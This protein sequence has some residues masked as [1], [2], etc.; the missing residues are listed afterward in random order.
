MKQTLPIGTKSKTAGA[1]LLLL[2]AGLSTNPTSAQN[3]SFRDRI[4]ERMKERMAKAN[5]GAPEQTEKYKI[6]GLD[7][8]VWRPQ[9]QEKAP[10]VI[11]S[12]G[13][14]G[15][16]TQSVFIM[17]AMA[18]A[19]YLVMAP[20]HKDARFGGGL[21][22][23]VSFVK[24][25]SWNDQT[26][27]DRRNDIVNLLQALHNDPAW[28][29]QIDWSKLALS[30]HSLGGYTALGLAGAWPS[31][32]IDGVKAVL[33]LS[34]YC[35]GFLEKGTLAQMQVPIMYQGGTDDRGITPFLKKPGG[36][37][38]QTP[39]PVYFV[40]FD[41]FTHFSW[42]GFNKSKEQQDL[43]NY[44]SINFLDK[45]VKGSADTKPLTKLPGVVEFETK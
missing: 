35:G 20:N 2:L 40:D 14:G 12:H 15:V 24:S 39:A 23:E 30:G 19:G 42:T 25:G 41:N 33:A 34:P 16:N 22:P 26:Y 44:Y 13:F 32:K 11:F 31:W 21:K 17:K 1:V 36:A 3:Q 27:A 6:A 9:T 5:T 38:D 8:A 43:T 7:V 29:K 4:R 28:D 45:Y 37:F 18:Q 10:L